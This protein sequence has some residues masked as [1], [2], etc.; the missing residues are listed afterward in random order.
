MKASSPIHRLIDCSPDNQAPSDTDP[1]LAYDPAFWIP[2]N[3]RL[4]LQV[5]GWS[6]R[7]AEYLDHAVSNTNRDLRSHV[8]RIYLHIVRGD[9]EAAYGALV[10][11]F[12]V[13]AEGGQALRKRLLGAAKPI[14]GDEHHR[15]L[16]DRL[17]AG[18]TANDVILECKASRLSKGIRQGHL[19]VIKHESSTTVTLDPLQEAR[20]H[21]DYGQVQ[22]AKEVLEAAII[23]QPLRAEIHHDLLEI[24]RSLGAREAFY[25]MRERLEPKTD[26]VT[27]A[28]QETSSFFADRS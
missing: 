27:A 21:L 10:D 19:L 6:E 4:Q 11:L 22:E 23:K 28:W 9:R 20:D 12:I 2:G 16:Q 25:N 24:Y 5:N 1:A 26:A 7:A 14:L 15:F 17:E 13:L 18:I 8:Q 3:S